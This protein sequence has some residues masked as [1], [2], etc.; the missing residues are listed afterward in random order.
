MHEGGGGGGQGVPIDC[1]HVVDCKKQRNRLLATQLPTLPLAGNSTLTST[2]TSTLATL[3]G[4]KA[5]SLRSRAPKTYFR[6]ASA[7]ESCARLIC[8]PTSHHIILLSVQAC[9]ALPSTPTT[10]STPLLSCRPCWLLGPVFIAD[11]AA[12]LVCQSFDKVSNCV[13]GSNRQIEGEREKERQKEFPGYTSVES[14]LAYSSRLLFASNFL[15]IPHV[16]CN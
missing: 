15:K 10:L 6:I 13:F 8:W 7:G 4:K 1:K 12:Q 2:T 14:C 3:A 11:F 5:A 16:A 9:H